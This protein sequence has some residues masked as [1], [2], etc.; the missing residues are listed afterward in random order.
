MG[1]TYRAMKI[2]GCEGYE[3][4]L[5]KK[6]KREKLLSKDPTIILRS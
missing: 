2:D 5:F 3:M 6:A 1:S 4:L